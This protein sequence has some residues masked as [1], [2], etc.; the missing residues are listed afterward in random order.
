MASEQDTLVMVTWKDKGSHSSH[1]FL[2]NSLSLLVSS[3][4]VDLL[5]SQSGVAMWSQTYNNRHTKPQE[6]SGLGWILLISIT[7]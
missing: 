4:T 3:Q 1:S 7:F 2:I 6:V 5:A